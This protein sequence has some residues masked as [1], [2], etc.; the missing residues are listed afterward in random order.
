MF[1]G[2][3]IAMT[4]WLFLVL[5]GIN[6]TQGVYEIDTSKAYFILVLLTVMG[7]VLGSAVELIQG[8]L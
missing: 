4:V 3:L 7:I 8:T 1:Y 6:R 2:V 5:S